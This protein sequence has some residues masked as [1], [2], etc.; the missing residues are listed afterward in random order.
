MPLAWTADGKF[1]TNMGNVAGMPCVAA[2]VI[3]A[4]QYFG[5]SRYLDYAIHKYEI[6]YDLRCKDL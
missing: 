6:Y 3:K 5:D 4:Y 2:L 1:P